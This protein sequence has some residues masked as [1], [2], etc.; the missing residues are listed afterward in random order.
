MPDWMQFRAESYAVAEFLAER[1]G[2]AFIGHL[3]DRLA[4]GATVEQAL[5]DAPVGPHHVD[6]LDTEWQSW[7][8]SHATEHRQGRS[9]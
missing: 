8:R 2:P 4:D 7:L 6:E 1:E 9:Y 3:A 5:E